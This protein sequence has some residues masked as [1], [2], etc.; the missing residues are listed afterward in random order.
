MGDLEKSDG[1]REGTK[2]IKHGHACFAKATK[3]GAARAPL[4]GAH[5]TEA[6]LLRCRVRYFTDGLVL[7]S[8]EFVDRVFAMTRKHFG[9]RRTSGARK[10]ARAD[11]GL[12]T[13][14]AL[15]VRLYGP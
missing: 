10:L 8:R 13:M 4:G 14:R 1:R 2:R 7:G 15:K 11:T 12:R 6:Q 5:L 9:A 3:A